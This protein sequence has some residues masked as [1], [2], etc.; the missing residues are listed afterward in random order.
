L[1]PYRL[2][3]WINSRIWSRKQAAPN[4]IVDRVWLGRIPSEAELKRAGF[5]AILDLT[6]EFN[7]PHSV[8]ERY[9]IPMLDLTVPD[10]QTLRSAARTLESAHQS[11]A[12]ILVCCALGY[13]RSALTVAA[14][15]LL[16]GRVESANKAIMMIKARRPRVI[17]NET[18][19][20]V[21][22]ALSHDPL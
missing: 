11:G 5:D 14:W 9:S 1:A 21:L 3:A 22:K 16:S 13:S 6:A 8:T 15:L 7:T 4:Q 19:H 10:V 12:R 17:F 20:Q 18:H 2:G